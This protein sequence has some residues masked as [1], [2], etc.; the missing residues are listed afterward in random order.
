MSDYLDPNN[1]ELLRDFF[2]EAQLQVDIMEQNILVLENDSSDR[3][4]VDELFRAAHTLKGAAATVQ[5]DELT[6]FTHIVEDVLDEVRNDTIEVTESVV[7]IIL[8]AIDVIKLMLEARL[9]GSVYDDGDDVEAATLKLKHLLNGEVAAIAAQNALNADNSEAS[10]LDAVEDSITEYEVYE[11]FENAGKGNPVYRVRVGFDEHAL[12][13]TVGGI[14][15]YSILKNTGVVLKTNPD[16]ESL[17]DDFYHAVVFYYITTDEPIETIRERVYISDVTTG[18]QVIQVTEQII[19]QIVSQA[20][21]SVENRNNEM[22]TPDVELNVNVAEFENTVIEE[23][24]NNS[25][26]ESSAVVVEP[27]QGSIVPVKTPTKGFVSK[28]S[29]KTQSKKDLSSILRVDSRKIDNL[30]NMVS[31]AVI[32]KSTINRVTVDL[33]DVQSEFQTILSSMDF[34][35]RTMIDSIP[36]LSRQIVEGRDSREVVEQYKEKF[37]ESI[38]AYNGFESRLKKSVTDLK[39]ASQKLSINTGNLQEGIMKIRMVPI[40][41]IFSRFP[42]LVRDLSHSLDKNIQLVLQGEDTELDKSVIEDLLDPLIHCVRNSIDH[43]IESPAERSRNGKSDEGTITLKASNEGSM[44]LIEVIDDGKGI[45]PA[46]IIK[47][48]VEKGLIANDAAISENEV[49]DLLFE[50]GFSTAEKVTNVSG[51]GVGMDVVKTQI[52]KLKGSIVV[53]SNQGVGTRISIRL[54]LTLAIIQGLLVRVGQEVYSIP[55]TSVVDSH[56]ISQEDIKMVDSY[57]VFNVRNEVVFLTR[58]NKLF[59]IPGTEEKRHKYVVIV[60]SAEKKMGLIVDALIGEE[61]VVI[62][63]LK[64]EFSNTPGIAGATILGDGKVSLIIDVTQL[65]ELGAIK[66]IQSRQRI[67]VLSDN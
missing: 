1:E 8:I 66:Q 52:E 15:I 38:S 5:M 12:M 59:Q 10:E 57:E 7:D 40:S 54:P 22:N 21:D 16:F 67:D 13:N 32:N 23:T 2:E 14:Q 65:L 43:G 27:T 11:L 56:R 46:Q 28:K 49:Y 44:I 34:E 30:L 25:F 31:E 48:A 45:N 51:R 41:N 20:E 50:P 47:K 29:K 33:A 64:D 62:K 61:D 39:N 17:N 58:L 36:E 6:E 37:E 60:G 63:P 3:D 53:T 35:I 26:V 9:E 55:V 24:N 19:D 4:S 42:R 18:S